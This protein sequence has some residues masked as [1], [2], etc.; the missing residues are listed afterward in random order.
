MRTNPIRWPILAAALAACQGAESNEAGGAEG[1]FPPMPVE[2]VPAVRDTV[3]DAIVATGQI[4]AVQAIELRPEVE[5][6]IVEIFVR[7]GGAVSQGAPLFKVDDAELKAQVAQLE[8]ER[9]LAVQ[10]LNRTR[11]LLAQNASSAADLERAEA[12]ARSTQAQLELAQLRLERTVVRA[13][14]AGVAGQRFVSLGDYVTRATPLVSLQTVDP[15]RAVFQVPERYARELA[16]GQRVTFGVASVAERRFTGT[17]QFVDPRVQ[18]PARTIMVKAVV[19]NPQR[20]LRA[21]M[22]IEVRLV[23]ETRPDAVLV[24]EDA[25]LPLEGANVVWVVTN[26]SAHRREVQLG[27]R[28]PGFVE[29]QSGI[30]AGEHVVVGG[31]ERLGEGAPVNATVVERARDGARRPSS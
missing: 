10:A 31:Q 11:E 19:R 25:V 29:V 2:V 13:P 15:Q 30:E 3:V 20:L 8:A 22:F 27:V 16:I 17:V 4:E 14:F 26:G 1:G 5:G 18:L 7:E 6:R 28:V 21:G 9:D 24:P 23:S 12:T